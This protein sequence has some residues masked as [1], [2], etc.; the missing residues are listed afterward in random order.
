M[1]WP[2]EDI[3]HLLYLSLFSSLEAGTLTE[4]THRLIASKPQR[5]SCLH[6]PLPLPVPTIVTWVL[7]I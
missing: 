3:E 6:T 2:E 5:S 7:G 4:P 1:R